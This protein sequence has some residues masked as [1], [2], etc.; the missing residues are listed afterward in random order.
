MA[1]NLVRLYHITEDEAYGNLAEDQLSFMSG[2][3]DGYPAG[4]SFFLLAL[5]MHEVPPER[6]TVVLHED[7]DKSQLAQQIPL[8]AAVIVLEHPTEDYPLV[9]N[10]TTYYVCKNHA[11]HPPV[12]EIKP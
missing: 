10:K 2:A 1:Y 8:G 4:Y 6:I 9:N 12:N 5:S 7:A 11:C 3:A